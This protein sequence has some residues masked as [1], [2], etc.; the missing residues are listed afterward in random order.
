MSSQTLF[1]TER[2]DAERALADAAALANVRENHL[3]AA[4]A[5]DALADRASRSD[6]LR[7]DEIRRKEE[8]AVPE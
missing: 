1:F 4:A 7:A 3:R 8:R 2:G 5:W 6:R